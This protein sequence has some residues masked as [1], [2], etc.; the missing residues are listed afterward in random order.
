MDEK[1]IKKENISRRKKEA[2]YKKLKKAIDKVKKNTQTIY[3]L[4]KSTMFLGSV[5]PR[6]PHSTNQA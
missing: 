2:S 3:R 6:H 1:S 4:P 5:R